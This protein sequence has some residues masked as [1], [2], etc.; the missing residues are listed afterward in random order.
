MEEENPRN[1]CWKCAEKLLKEYE[2]KIRADVI[3]EFYGILLD[4]LGKLGMKI[5]MKFEDCEYN[6]VPAVID[7]GEEL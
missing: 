1:V 4:E 7:K 5:A 6:D 3:D 2:N